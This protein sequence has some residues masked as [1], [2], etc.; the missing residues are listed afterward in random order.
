MILCVVAGLLPTIVV[1]VY[2][3]HR[4]MEMVAKNEVGNMEGEL[5]QAVYA[6]ENQ[7][8]IYDSLID[9]L[10]YSG[11]LREI[12]SLEEDLSFD[13]YLKYIEVAD[14]LLQIPQIY[15]KEMKSIT[16]YGKNILVEHGTTL[17]PLEVAKE[18]EWYP[19]EEKQFIRWYVD[20][21]RKKE[22]VV[23]RQFFDENKEVN[24]ILAIT[25]DYNKMFEPLDNIIDTNFSGI[26][27]N[28]S[29]QVIY[30]RNKID[31]TYEEKDKITSI[32]QIHETNETNAY[33]T[34]SMEETGWSFC[35]YTPKEWMNESVKHLM[36]ENLPIL[37][38]CVLLLLVVSYLFSK[39]LVLKLEQLTQNMNQI[40]KGDRKVTVTTNSN[41][42]IGVLITSFQRM[43]DEINYLISKV[44]EGKIKL[45]RTELKA[46]QAQINPHFLYNSLS[47]INWKAIE[48]GEMEIS[49]VTLALSTYYRTSLN[50]GEIITTM[51]NELNN[52]RA[53]L[54]VQLVIHD[55][56]FSVIESIDEEL[57]Q[58][59][60]PKLIL[61]PIIENAID[62]GIDVS[63]KE[64]K[65]I[66]IELK[67]ENNIAIL[68]VEDNGCGMEQKKAEEI[69]SYC[70][71][72]YGLKNVKERIGLIYQ[73]ECPITIES[74]E[75]IGTKV[76]LRMKIHS[77][78]NIYE[79][80]TT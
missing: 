57:L 61:Q 62:H 30:S 6:I 12:L 31:K 3:Q 18:K 65:W 35:Y 53:Y 26:V 29:G 16:L 47:I 68:S 17:A 23:L 54:N 28:E 63:E 74:K 52:A 11:D 66:K 55:N 20:T 19:R 14:P 56:N 58:M 46:L 25:L 73:E 67:K 40:H 51:E 45:Q 38:V 15:H 10:S 60:V 37:A 39:R 43:M 80:S 59:K 27:W 24:A 49:K 33:V 8:Q 76:I 13:T 69:I 70:S 42:E 36:W 5:Q 48:A 32:N 71:K 72:G 34:V 78:G 2:M 1:S 50:K 64:E 75:G 77:E 4:M 21:A 41:D 79:A 44:Y 22:V 9:Y 7:T